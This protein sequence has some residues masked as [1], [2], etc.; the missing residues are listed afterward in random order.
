M[1]AATVVAELTERFPGVSIS[2]I[3]GSQMQARGCR[4]LH[5][6]DMLNVMG[7]SDVLRSLRRIRRIEQ[8]VMGWCA[9]QQPDVAIL[10][11]FSSFHIRLGRKLRQQGIPVI[12]FIAPKLWAWGAWRVSRLQ[13]SQDRLACILPFEPDWFAQHGISHAAYVGNPSAV[14]CQQGW[15]QAEL[16]QHLKIDEHRPLLALLPGSRPQEWRAHVS[17]LADTLAAAQQQL[18]EL[19]CVVPVMPGVDMAALQA[20]WDLGAMPLERTTPGYAMRADAAVAVSGTATLELALWGTPTVLI[21]MASPM[22]VF[23]AR[24]LVKVRCAGLANII[25]HDEAVMPELIQ[26][27][28]RLPHIMSTLMPLLHGGEAADEQR[29]QFAA[30]K[31]LLG[32]ER[33]ARGVVNLVQDLLQQ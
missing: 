14:S 2:G 30:L 11:D 27:Q 29:R 31:Q 16:K 23:L 6:M 4:A 20:L 32:N 24:R 22:M 7:I 17:I 1:H 21:Y 9:K 25:M 10:V 5:H 26:E 19:A 12:H 3:A 33:P 28:C 18:P 15:S 13:R 8:S